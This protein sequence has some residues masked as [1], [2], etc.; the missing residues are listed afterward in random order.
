MIACVKKVQN[1]VIN[2]PPHGQIL[3]I[4]WQL[5]PAPVKREALTATLTLNVLRAQHLAGSDLGG[6]QKSTPFYCLSLNKSKL[7]QLSWLSGR[8]PGYPVSTFCPAAGWL[9][10]S[11]LSSPG[12]SS[13]LWP[14]AMFPADTGWLHSL[15]SS[16][17]ITDA[18]E[19][20]TAGR[21]E[22]IP[23]NCSVIMPLGLK[24]RRNSLWPECFGS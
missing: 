23:I 13:R 24:K 16:W 10:R 4:S 11:R 1:L 5:R 3:G 20:G 9:F 19:W 12:F 18:R 17:K 2:K 6:R 14:I 8:F 21:L 22:P 15:A 7:L